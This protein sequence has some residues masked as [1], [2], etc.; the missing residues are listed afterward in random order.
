MLPKRLAREVVY[1]NEWVNL[2]LDKVAYPDG[3]VIEKHHLVHFDYPSVGVVLQNEHGEVLLIKSNRYTTQ[4]EEWEIPAGG[5]EKGESLVQAAAREVLE[6]TGCTVANLQ[7][8]C[9]ENPL[10]GITDKE[11]YIFQGNVTQTGAPQTPE[12][13]MDSRWFALPTLRD[14]IAA[15]EIRCDMTLIGLLMVLCGL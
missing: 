15:G 11:H 1:E 5:V 13:V 3:R 10:N 14:M 2:Y 6:E 12:E 9:K 7:L 8:L 4:S